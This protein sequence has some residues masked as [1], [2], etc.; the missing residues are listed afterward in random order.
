MKSL[1]STDPIY[2]TSDLCK[3]NPKNPGCGGSGNGGSNGGNGNGANGGGDGSGG[4]QVDILDPISGNGGDGGDGGNGGGDGGNGNGG[5]IQPNNA[6][7][8]A[9][10]PDYSASG[11][12]ARKAALIAAISKNVPGL[13]LTPDDLVPISV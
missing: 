3:I 12:A 13:Q 2:S 6:P 7:S 5:D 11:I 4:N 1:F 8:G 9:T 10:G